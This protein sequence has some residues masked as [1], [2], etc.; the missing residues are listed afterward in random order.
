MYIKC[1]RLMK[2]TLAVKFTATKLN[3]EKENIK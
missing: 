2:A 3:T 1:M